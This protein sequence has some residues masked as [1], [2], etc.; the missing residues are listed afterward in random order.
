MNYNISIHLLPFLKTT[1]APSRAFLHLTHPQP[2]FATTDRFQLGSLHIYEHISPR[3]V[4]RLSFSDRWCQTHPFH[5]T[6]DWSRQ[7]QW[8]RESWAGFGVSLGQSRSNVYLSGS[9]P[10]HRP[11]NNA[12]MNDLGWA[13]AQSFCLSLPQEP[14][15]ISPFQNK[16]LRVT[17]YKKGVS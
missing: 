3:L 12:A 5:L 6:L 16:M 11:D 7:S 14:S 15:S 2:L 10:S 8:I 1:F 9:N 13:R 4:P 17:D